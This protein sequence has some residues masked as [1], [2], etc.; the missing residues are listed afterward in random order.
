MATVRN[1]QSGARSTVGAASAR[2]PARA[3]TTATSGGARSTIGAA[4]TR[5]GAGR[6]AAGAPTGSSS[7][8]GG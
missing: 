2:Q 4:S 7:R 8:G 3:A 5:Q 1:P 6:R